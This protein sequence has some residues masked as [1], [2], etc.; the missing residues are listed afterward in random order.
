[1]EITSTR[2]CGR[3]ALLAVAMAAGLIALP[4]RPAGAATTTI[5]VTSRVS[6]T[7]GGGQLADGAVFD[8][9]VD[10]TG[11]YAFFTTK[12]AAVADDTNGAFD[13]YRRDRLTGT[14]RRVS[15]RGDAD[16]ITGPSQ[17]CGLST[18]GR[19]VGFQTTGATPDLANQIW[20]RDLQEQ[21]TV[22]ITP[23]GSGSSGSVAG[24]VCPVSDDGTRVLFGSADPSVG[25]GSTGL[26]QAVVRR[27]DTG[28]FSCTSRSNGGAIANEAAAPRAMSATGDVV[29][30]VTDAD[31]L[32]AGDTNATY[33]VYFRQ[34]STSATTR[35]TA[36]GGVQLNGDTQSPSL[37]ATGRYVSFSSSASNVVAGDTN[38]TR[39][40]FRLDRQT[41][42]FERVSVTTS[43]VEGN[44]YSG[45]S[46]ISGDGRHVA[47]ASDSTN[48]YP[49]DTNGDT[50]IFR[51][52]L[53][54]DRT[55]LASRVWNGIAVGN[56][57]SWHTPD[58]SDD[59]R[60]VAFESNA[61]NLVPGDTNGQRDHVVRDFAVDIAPF[62]SASAFAEQQLVD[63]APPNAY[64]APP[65]VDSTAKLLQHGALSPDGLVAQ[66]ARSA[67][68]TAKRSPLIRLYW[69]FFLRAPDPSGMTYWTKQLTNGKTL[70]QVA[71]KFA[72]SSEFQTKYGSKSNEQFVTLIY[73]NI[74][75][76]D[77]DPGG[78][79]YWTG[80][81][82]AK[83][84]TR[85]DV[86]TN[87]SESSEGRRFLAPQVDTV[88]IWLGM[89][90][91][92]PPKA[93]LTTWIADIRSGAKVAE[94]VA[95]K[96]RSL[97]AYAARVAA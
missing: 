39:D 69:A 66:Q 76:R 59:G 93:E 30:Y 28:T 90:R 60:T 31:N 15:L 79:A 71:A 21:S 97:P 57:P 68:W 94:Q 22:R 70:A 9:K 11:R 53:D 5:P 6:T 25:C 54:L 74:F 84:K 62:G 8:P 77:P 55:D 12:T 13:V 56:A 80:K 4:A 67:S 44:G 41:G 38:A 81:L 72:Q 42:G 75:E 23:D 52:D 40:V 46:S 3:G 36:A 89:L 86:M 63:F 85:G 17:L 48:L 49:A 51:R 61:T 83:A 45:A 47:F 26:Q 24:T 1:M 43:G 20:V 58:I 73:Q 92:M 32:V 78:L 95:T 82:D 87:F 18:S 19:F 29:A 27:T 65:A 10:G 34:I 37:S 96:I 2:R 88:N 7:T 14:V 91:T 64:P 35:I 16:Q 50:D 33:D